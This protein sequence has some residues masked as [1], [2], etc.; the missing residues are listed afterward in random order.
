M[1]RGLQHMAHKLRL[2]E[3]GL[4]SLEKKCSGKPNS[5][6]VIPKRRFQRRWS[7]AL[8]RHAR[9]EDETGITN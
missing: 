9:W 3:M 5:N 4:V 6:F 2:G 7:Q 1:A 8:Y